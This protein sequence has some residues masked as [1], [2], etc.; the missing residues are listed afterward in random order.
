MNWKNLLIGGAFV[1]VF[2]LGAMFAPVGEPTATTNDVNSAGK[3]SVT[4]VADEKD[5][6]QTETGDVNCPMT[7]APMG[8]GAGMGHY[9]AGTM[10]EVIADVLGM[11]VDELQT[12]RNEGKSVADLAEE[13][14]INVD[15]L[16]AKMVETRKA[17]LEQLVKDGKIT[18]EQMDTMLSNMETKMKTAV[19]RD[20]VGPMHG[21][22]GGMGMM[23]QGGRW[24]GNADSQEL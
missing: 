9:F 19:E 11:T 15:D 2:T 21:R 23:G 12:A 16:V 4:K 6:S 8:K 10:P 24:T 3:V 5:T 7:G 18:Q 14:G 13:K 20:S 17:D 1:G 22:G